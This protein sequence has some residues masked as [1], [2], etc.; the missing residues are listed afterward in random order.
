MKKQYFENLTDLNEIKIRYKELAKAHHPDLGGCVEVMKEIN[1]QYDQ[2][3]EGI[4][5]K[6]GKSITEIEELLKESVEMRNKLCEVIGFPGLIV[7]LCGSWIWITGETRAVKEILKSAG[8]YWAQKKLAWYWHK[9]EEG[10][11]KGF[12]GKFTMDEI[13]SR[14][15]AQQI[16]SL[17]KAQMIA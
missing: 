10:K 9:K 1:S 12:R 16:T 8:F 5:Q 11:T 14:H 2:V 15:G 6:S 17:T 3:L 7:E 4:Y 13:R